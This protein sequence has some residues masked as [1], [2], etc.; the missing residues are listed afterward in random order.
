MEFIR[1][2]QRVNSGALQ[3]DRQRLHFPS[4]VQQVGVTDTRRHQPAAF[5]ANLQPPEYFGGVA[6][7][8]VS[9]VQTVEPVR[10]IFLVKALRPQE[11]VQVS[12][13]TLDFDGFVVRCAC[14]DSGD[15]IHE[16]AQ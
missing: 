2:D 1:E 15:G 7:G 13:C 3:V 12:E 6:D 5:H 4:R 14:A 16:L 8:I 9:A 11:Q 10:M